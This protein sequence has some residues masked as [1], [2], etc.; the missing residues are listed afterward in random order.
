MGPVKT[1]GPPRE[2]GGDKES[3]SSLGHYLQ[4]GRCAPCENGSANDDGRA[5]R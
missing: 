5:D 4:K 1:R 2:E 3:A